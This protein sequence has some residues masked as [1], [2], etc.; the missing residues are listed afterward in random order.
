MDCVLWVPHVVKNIGAVSP[1]IYRAI[2]TQTLVIKSINLLIADCVN[3]L[4]T[5][6][7]THKIEIVNE[8]TFT[9]VICLLSWLPLMRVIRSGYLTWEYQ[10]NPVKWFYTP[11]SRRDNEKKHE[12]E[13]SQTQIRVLPWERVEVEMFQLNNI[14]DQQNLQETNSWS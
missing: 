12:Q 10:R 1:D 14:H 8:T 11:F 3:S 4:N 5:Y 2:F 9:C 7:Y 13:Q 6:I